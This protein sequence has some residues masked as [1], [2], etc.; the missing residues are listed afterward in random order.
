MGKNGTRSCP[1]PTGR[2]CAWYNCPLGRR[3][4]DQ[5]RSEHKCLQ[6]RG[7]HPYHD[8]N[9]EGSSQTE[10]VDALINKR[11]VA[12]HVTDSPWK[13]WSEV[14]TDPI[15]VKEQGLWFLAIFSSNAG[16]TRAARASGI[17]TL[18]PIGVVVSDE[19]QEKA[20]LLDA[21]FCV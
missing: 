3:F 19:V 13:V 11:N 8:N 5:C 20:D 16:I 6:C 1:S 21:S 15:V 10:T 14:P 12:V 4:A 2:H 18:P 17:P 9:Q 7:D